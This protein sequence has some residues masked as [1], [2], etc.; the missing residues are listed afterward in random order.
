MKTL[1]LVDSSSMFF[2]AFFALPP[3]TNQAGMQT[4]ALYGF[5][6][7]TIKLLRDCKPDYL[8]YCFDRKEPSF[9]NEM[10]E[11]YKANRDE[12]PDAL[13]PQ[14]PYMR[15]LTDALGI[16]SVDKLGYE[17]DDVIGTLALWGRENNME[18]TIVSGDKDFAQ[19]V[20]PCIT[21][22]DTMKD[23]RLDSE[24]VKAKWG[25]R[26]D[27]IIDYL[28]IVGDTSD[29]IP[30]VKGVG[31]KGAVKL[32][33]EFDTL[34]NVYKDV[35]KISAA[36]VRTK[37]QESEK[38]AELARKLLTIVTDLD[39][40]L[41]LSDMQLHTIDQP[42]F[43][44]LM[45]ELGFKNFEKTLL[46]ID[47]AKKPGVPLVMPPL[48]SA[49]MPGES[50]APP[51]VESGP[52]KAAPKRAKG[53]VIEFKDWEAELTD[54]KKGIE[55]YSELWAVWSD[56]GPILAS[57]NRIIR[58]SADPVELGKLLASKRLR[59]RG[60][61]LKEIYKHLKI[62]SEISSWDGKL[63]AYVIRPEKMGTF[64]E[65]YERYCG[66]T[67]PPLPTAGQI[68]SAHR[69]LEKCLSDEIKTLGVE[70]V[71]E[72]LDLPLVSVL[73]RMEMKGMA[74]DVEELKRQSLGLTE[75]IKRLEKSIHEAA[76]GSFNI[77]SPK[78]L[79][80]VLFEKLK[81]PPKKKTKTGYSTD[82]DV[83][84]S[85]QEINPIAGSILEYR[86]LSKLKSTYV[87]AL[88]AMVNSET[89]R[90]HTQLN[91]TLTTTGRLS[92]NNP[93]LQNIPI[94]TERGRLVRKAFIAE[95]GNV[96]ISADYSQIE[97]RVLAHMSGDN[98]L[99]KAFQEDHDIHA[100]TA[101]EIFGIELDKV[102]D[103]QRRSAKAVN[104]GIA[105]GQGA[106]GLSQNL[107]IPRK[108][109]ADIIERY[110]ARFAKVKKYMD[111]ITRVALETGYVETLFG[112]RRYVD[113]LKSQNMMIRRAGERAAINAPIQGTAADLVKLAM[114]RLNESLPI[115]LILQ[116]HDELLFECPKED[117]EVHSAEI[118]RTMEEIHPLAVPLKVNVSS[119]TSWEH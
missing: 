34:N 40:G 91:Q 73:A 33:T 23:V 43:V 59:W 110:F 80:E 22:Y 114:T 94:R 65:I 9:R 5:M 62:S 4:N 96:L 60:W 81:L 113:E 108:E 52:K 53:G 82:S 3:L 92:S 67:L 2:R 55:P 37:M 12:M 41:K 87:D 109:A 21:L 89:H 66:E 11:D 95:K 10:Y 90:L 56:R 112:R 13:I 64:E 39:L 119:G 85:L 68:M 8:V 48:S 101:A 29:N 31:P 75:D 16:C 107:G 18:V 47:E 15:K 50:D 30:G 49:P 79:G 28:A 38:S 57:E 117:V 115:P 19:L 72:T 111:E 42:N 88:P 20:R 83:L 63:A 1:Y 99:I 32:L 86:E 116:V 6:T 14:I 46:Q 7:M 26:P 71:L 45:Q 100:A 84:E 69:Q 17:A 118:R 106:Q 93:N 24:G 78:Q 104:F 103:T 97:L 74:L 51:G 70:K 77:A 44:A 54:L 36:G 61:E 102:N 27:Q 76:G 35:S 105:Y 58:T 25:V 98:G